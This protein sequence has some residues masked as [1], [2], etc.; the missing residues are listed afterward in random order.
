MSG[1]E[2]ELTAMHTSVNSLYE[3]QKQLDAIIT[4]LPAGEKFA[5]V[6]RDGEA[7]LKKLKAWD[8]EMIQR[9]SKAYD[10][11]ENFVNKLTANYLFLVNQTE[12]DLPRINQSSLDLLEKMTA[13]WKTL[14][15]R[16]DEITVKEIPSLNRRLWDLGYGAIWKN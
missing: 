14:K 3:K 12:S 6:K 5:A 7:L 16:A 2:Q 4:A 15:A 10:D 11:V 1:M 9:R 13:E 8:E